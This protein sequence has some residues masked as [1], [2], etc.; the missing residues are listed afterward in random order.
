MTRATGRKSLVLHL[1]V[2][3]LLFL[4]QFVL[5]EYH[6]LT[7]TR[8]MILAVFALGYNVL[9]GYTGLLS[10][11]HAMFFACGLYAAGL[12]VYHLGWDVLPAFLFAVAVAGAAAAA[13]GM[14]ALRT[15]GVAFMIV[16][17]MF[18]QVVY[19][20]TLYFSRYTR[21]DEGLVLPARARSFELVGI[22]VNLADPVTRYY[23]ALGLLAAGILVVHRL[24]RSGT[25]REWIAVREN[26]SR[27]RMLGYNT[28]S[29]KLKALTVSGALSGAAG[30]AYALLF[31]YVGSTF[32]SIQYS[33]DALLFTLLGG[34][35]TVLGP[36]LGSFIM[37][38]LIDIFSEY[39]TAYLLATGVVLILLI[40]YFSVGILGTLRRKWLHW[41]P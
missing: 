15:T 36:V 22:H 28:F 20:A 8:I 26:E 27:T 9:F 1:G 25:G 37:F 34:A 29:I 16:T 32:A 33:I 39:T 24:V 18:S 10:L 17:L 40:L 38:Y 6:H 2:V 31:A 35:G 12:T 7:V 3:A 4:L 19:L 41:L 11:G 13:V 14:I 23:I 21:G 30:A 5:P